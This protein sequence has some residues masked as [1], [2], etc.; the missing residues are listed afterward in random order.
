MTF[1]KNMDN[2][3]IG[4]AISTFTEEKTVSKRYE[5]INSSLNFLRQFS[6]LDRVSDQRFLINQA[7]IFVFDAF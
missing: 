7:N 3:K 4:I 5:I 2:L 6:S 1:N